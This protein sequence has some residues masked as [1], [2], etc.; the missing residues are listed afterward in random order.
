MSRFAPQN[1]TDDNLST[2]WLY[3]LVADLWIS[4][5]W[6]P[7]STR[8]TIL[9]GGFYTLSPRKGFRIIALNSNVC[10]CYNWYVMGEKKKKRT[11]FFLLLIP[12]L[13]QEIIFLGG[14][15]INTK[16]LMDNYSG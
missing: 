2:D 13:T 15:Y 9:Q 8:A 7:E 1:I 5:G 16:T 6:L 4:F 11:K 14:Y 12:L 10:Y 3:S